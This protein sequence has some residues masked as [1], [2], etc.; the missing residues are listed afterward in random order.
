[1]DDWRFRSQRPGSA[2]FIDVVTRTYDLPDG[3]TTDWDIL[4]LGDAAAVLAFTRG[5]EV[6]LVRQFRPGPDR[7]LD[8]L[9]GGLIDPGESPLDAAARELLEE[10][11]Y[12]GTIEIVGY[13]WLMA[14]ATRRQWVAVARDC[15]RVAEPNLGPDEFCETVLVSLD[16]FRRHLRSGQL[17]DVDLGYLALD[18][19]GLLGGRD[20][21][22]EAHRDGEPERPVPA[23]LTVQ[24]EFALDAD[25]LKHIERRS[26]LADGSRRENSA[27]HSWHLALMAMVLAE[28]AAQPVDLLHVLQ[29]L[30]IHDLVEIDAGDT[31][32]YDEAARA[33]KAELE[34]LA[35]RR[36]FGQLPAEQ[37][38]S[39]LALWEEYETSETPAARFGHALDRLQPLML[40]RASGG[41]TWTEHGI[42]ADRVRD[43]NRHIEDGSEALWGAAQAIISDAVAR[44]YLAER[45]S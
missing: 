43:V 2:G 6:V 11:G 39:L 35:A 41:T 45:E 38:Q 29:M 25:R 9:P 36:I 12:R 44:G 8:E 22:R 23:R 42:T 17:T 15:E 40:N 20:T 1:M 4:E 32:V 26:R 3:T 33:D 13:C 19:L 28:H 18:H 37:A 21:S 14:P 16:E 27:E 30:I 7:V 10:T 34:S 5:G 31:F 24:L